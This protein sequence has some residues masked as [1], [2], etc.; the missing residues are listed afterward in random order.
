MRPATEHEASRPSP[1]RWHARDRQTPR[2][3][4][5]LVAVLVC[6]IVI[7]LMC[8]A[9]LRLGLA[10]REW[11]RADERQVQ[12][13]WLAESGLERAAA[14]LA[15]AADYSGETWEPPAAD[16]GGAWGGRVT[17]AVQ[18]V[19]GHPDRRL[20]RV[21]ADYP[22]HATL[23]ARK[24]KQAVIELQSESSGEGP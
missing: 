7:I 12:S 24:T 23:K 5:V 17:I 18:A 9:L 4:A 10:Q 8:G 2:R 11:L 1:T 3:G 15:A 22:S 6:V 13:S 16:L 19:E 14:R 20:V 21:Q